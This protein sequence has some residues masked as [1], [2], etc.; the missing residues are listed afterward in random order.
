MWFLNFVIEKNMKIYDKCTK[1][2]I[3]N[4]NPIREMTDI[5]NNTDTSS[6]N[7]TVC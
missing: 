5:E 6:Q 3:S 4:E 1:K 7:E 2:K